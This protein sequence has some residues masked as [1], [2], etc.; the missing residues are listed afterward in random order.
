MYVALQIQEFALISTVP[1]IHLWYKGAHCMVIQYLQLS[2]L[3]SSS[4]WSCLSGIYILITSPTRLRVVTLASAKSPWQCW[5]WLLLQWAPTFICSLL[6]AN[7]ATGSCSPFGVG[8]WLL[9]THWVFVQQELRHLWPSPQDTQ[10]H[11]WLQPPWLPP[12]SL[13]PLPRH[14]VGNIQT[15]FSDQLLKIFGIPV[16][17][18]S[19]PP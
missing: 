2:M 5:S 16:V 14:N 12:H 13:W 7:D 19:L 11:I 18:L 15:S 9:S 10:I 8:W 3:R 1:Y 17:M 4:K 6:N